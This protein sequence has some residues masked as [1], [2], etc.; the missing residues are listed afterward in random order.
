MLVSNDDI[1]IDSIT[2]EELDEI[3]VPQ[4][5]PGNLIDC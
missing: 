2:E 5:I 1:N 3:L 4:C